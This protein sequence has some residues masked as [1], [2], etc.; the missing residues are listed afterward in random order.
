M[1]VCLALNGIALNYIAEET[2][3]LVIRAARGIVDEQELAGWLR[4]LAL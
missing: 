2:G 3:Q 1:D 4:A